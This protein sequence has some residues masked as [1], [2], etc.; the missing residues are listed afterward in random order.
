MMELYQSLKRFREN[1]RLTQDDMARKMKVSRTMY[2]AYERGQA[3]P[4]VKYLINLA[5]AENVSLDYLAGLID[6]PR[7]TESSSQ[8]PTPVADGNKVTTAV[9]ALT[10]A[11]REQY[12]QSKATLEVANALRQQFEHQQEAAVDK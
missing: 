5:V 1:S 4:S 9:I 11:L 8:I 3:I 10:D 6:K 12:E 7:P 2:K